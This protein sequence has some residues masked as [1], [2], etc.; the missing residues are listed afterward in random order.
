VET[1]QFDEARKEERI[2]SGHDPADENV[3]H[4]GAEKARVAETEGDIAVP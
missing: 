1:G 2:A 4:I 3:A